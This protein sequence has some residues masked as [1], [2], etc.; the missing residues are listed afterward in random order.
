MVV[1]SMRS[2]VPIVSAMIVAGCGRVGFTPLDDALV[3]GMSALD[4][5]AVRCDWSGGPQF[6]GS[7]I[8]RDELSSVA[9]DLDPFLDPDDPLTIYLSS[10]RA[11]AGNDD[12]YVARRPSLGAAFDPPVAVPGLDTAVS[13]S[14]LSISSGGMRGYVS[15][16]TDLFEVRRPSPTAPF[17]IVRALDEINAGD[18]QFDP[19]ESPDRRSLTYTSGPTGELDIYTAT[20]TADTEPFGS[21]VS[22]VHNGPSNDSGATFTADRLIMAWAAPVGNDYDLFYATRARIEDPFGPAQ[23]LLST[24]NT[25]FEPHLRGDGCELFFV[26]LPDAG[27]TQSDIYSIGI[28][29]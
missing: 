29:P 1:A 14:G 13:E 21:P 15:R 19:V 20:R 26:Q 2:G 22:F 17:E 5:P 24:V 28:A 16:A 27:S 12:V 10:D 18:L 23:L 3:D 25:D 4:A 8:R 7:P 9:S 11:S 6:I